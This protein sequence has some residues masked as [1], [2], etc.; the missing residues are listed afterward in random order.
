[1]ESILIKGARVIDPCESI[2][3]VC[4]ILIKDGIIAGISEGICAPAAKII[5]AHRLIAAPGLVD[6][7]VHLRDPGFTY[8]EDII[9]GCKA[10]AAGGIT[11]V[12]CMPNTNPVLDSV[13]AL[14][15]VTEKA[16]Q[17]DIKVLPV[18]AVTKGQKGKELCDF[19][20][21]MEA[22]AVAFSDDGYPVQDDKLMR[23][24]M[25]RAKEL[26]LPIIS[27]CEHLPL[28][29]GGI[30]NQGK[31]SR[32]LG[33]KGIPALAEQA[34]VQ[35]DIALSK[36]I[37]CP[38]HIAH[39]SAKGAVCAI[40]EA[41]AR[42]VKVTCETAPH[43][44]ALTEQELLK[45]DANF[46]MNPPLR[47]EE[48]RQAI[49]EGL[50]DGTIDAIATDHA[51]H[52]QQEKTDFLSAPNGV[53]GLETSLSVGITELVNTKR[54]TL[55]E[56][57]FKMSCAPARIL[58]IAGGKLKVGQPADIVIFDRHEKWIVNPDEF[59]SKSRNTPFAD[60]ELYGRVKYTICSGKIVYKAQ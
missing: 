46:R 37:G 2:D 31:V 28:V 54:L 1:M 23:E 60:R 51:P 13:E 26:G 30:I 36:T 43:Y 57:I 58:G 40:R 34:M 33:V 39:V 21:L 27:H 20:E 47:T 53:I 6:M 9:S 15:Y 41:K 17:A 42:G 56:L 25:E 32:A 19:K 38:V 48:D 29:K 18:A 14:K 16:R 24:A 22:G 49:I 52:S 10:A 59:Y 45:R 55:G 3:A 50:I 11:A 12:A 35:R 44:F 8:K 4:D 5:E 7:H